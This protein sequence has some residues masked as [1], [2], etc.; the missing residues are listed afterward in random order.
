MSPYSLYAEDLATFGKSRDYEQAD[1]RGF[2]K[3]YGLP[4]TVAASVER[5]SRS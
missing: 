1:S 5:E 2:I 3:L 4:G